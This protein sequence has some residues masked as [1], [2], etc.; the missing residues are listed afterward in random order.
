MILQ[1]DISSIVLRAKLLL[2]ETVSEA[3]K[4]K[5]NGFIKEH[6]Q[7]ISEAHYMY[8]GIKFFETPN[9]A[10]P[11]EK[12]KVF[13]C[14]ADI[15][16]LY[17]VITPANTITQGE[18]ELVYATDQSSNTFTIFGSG[19]AIFSWGIETHT[20]NLAGATTF[21]VDFKAAGLKTVR[22]D[23]SDPDSVTAITAN[24]NGMI[25]VL[26]LSSFDNL[27][28]ADFD[29][30]R[31]TSVSLGEWVNTPNARFSL[32]YNQLSIDRVGAII[33]SI[34][35]KSQPSVSGRVFD[36]DFNSLA[37]RSKIPTVDG[38]RSSKSLDVVVDFIPESPQITV[39]DAASA[40]SISLDWL[41]YSNNEDGFLIERSVNLLE[42]EEI[43]D[44]PSNTTTFTDNSVSE[45]TTYYY[46]IRAKALSPVTLHF[47]E[48]SNVAQVTTPS[49]TF[50]ITATG[51][52]RQVTVSWADTE[53]GE[54]QWE[55]LRSPTSE[56]EYA[57]IS[58]LPADST[59]Y[60]DT[61]LPVATRY[62]YQVRVT[63]SNGN[64]VT[65]EIV[66]AQTNSGSFSRS[67]S[68][69]FS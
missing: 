9:D 49:D 44:L 54:S 6:D 13:Q 35:L 29:N 65:S 42:W 15:V 19:Q 21:T 53:D 20:Q 8:L 16:G 28:L 24:N 39:I 25:G 10:T 14:L 38:L 22:V 17:D 50:P 1:A 32:R 63:L 41:D 23:F 68:P 36:L 18:V 40:T 12:Q 55:V 33:D 61:S 30:N 11:K 31:F 48:Y 5:N 47:S 64:T 58:T 2:P 45:R 51:G 46:R 67:F 26:G 60:V 34:E 57:V 7:R 37:S 69:S 3:I 59:S 43:A 27:E 56:G 52:I 4:Y 62:W 66:S